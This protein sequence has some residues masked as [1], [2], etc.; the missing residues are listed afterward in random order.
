MAVDTASSNSFVHPSLTSSLTGKASLSRV[1]RIIEKHSHGLGQ[2]PWTEYSL[3]LGEHDGLQEQVDK[4]NNL[5]RRRKIRYDYE[6]FKSRLTIRMPSPLHDTF[7]AKVVRDIISQLES[8]VLN[9]GH[10]A[11]FAKDV[12]YFASSQID[13]PYDSADDN[14]LYAR[15]EP[16]ASFGHPKARYPGVVIEVC[17][18]QK[19][20]RI[21]ALADDY[22]LNSDGSIN[23]VVFLDIEYRGKEASFSIW[24][25]C[26]EIV[27]GVKELSAACVD[28][29]MFRTID[30]LP[31]E[32]TP[33]RLNL[34]D[35]ATEDE[36]EG[37]ADLDQEIT[38][39]ARDLCDY[40][41]VAESRQAAQERHE[42]SVKKMP[43]GTRKRR[44]AETP[45]DEIN[46]EDEAVFQPL[47]ESD[48]KRHR[49]SDYH[50]DS[51]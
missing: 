41:N 7:C 18:S 30:G 28:K 25:P 5:L 48:R 29:Q 14:T 43:T 36:T 37:Y 46:S 10:G 23:A 6:P 15:R 38:I 44:R 40:L 27:N 35:F 8:V 49:D 20:R 31:A 19:G 51:L 3:S 17:Y 33:L 47:E 50:P 1:A 16:D 26:F 9:G 39:S 11:D 34:K 24:Q 42:G 12:D 4:R 22:I 45:P 21:P 2:D 13:L 32:S